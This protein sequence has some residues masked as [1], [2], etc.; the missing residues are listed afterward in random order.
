M[1]LKDYFLSNFL[2]FYYRMKVLCVVAVFVAVAWAGPWPDDMAP[3]HATVAPRPYLPDW[4]K[5]QI[6]PKRDVEVA[7][8]GIFETIKD[9]VTS[10]L[11]AG[12]AIKE[13][14]Q[15]VT[16]RVN[17]IIDDIQEFYDDFMEANDGKTPTE[18]ILDVIYQK[19]HDE[20]L[21][22]LDVVFDEIDAVFHSVADF[23]DDNISGVWGEAI[24][25]KGIAHVMESIYSKYI[26]IML[27]TVRK[28]INLID[29]IEHEDWEAFVDKLMDSIE[30]NL[31]AK[32][33]KFGD[34]LRNSPAYKR[35]LVTR[36]ER[37]APYG[38]LDTIKD[39]VNGMIET[40]VGIKD[41]IAELTKTLNE[42]IDSLREFYEDY[43]EQ[44][45]KTPT[46]AF[47]EHVLEKLHDDIVKALDVVFDQIDDVFH[48]VAD[49]VDEMLEDVW[50]KELIRKGI[51]QLLESLYSKYIDAVLEVLQMAIDT[52]DFIEHEDWDAFV[53][54]LMDSIEASLDAKLDEFG[55]K[56]KNQGKRAVLMSRS[57]ED[58]STMG[59][60]DSIKDFAQG[61]LDAGVAIKEK[62]ADMSKQV[63]DALHTIAEWYK[64]ITADQDGKPVTDVILEKLFEKIVSEIGAIIEKIF[65]EIADVVLNVAEY[66]DEML[67]GVWEEAYIR[68]KIAGFLEYV[69]EKYVKTVMNALQKILDTIDF[70]ENNDWEA[71]ADGVVDIIESAMH[72]KLDEISEKIKDRLGL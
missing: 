44:E 49:Y 51:N 65:D 21:N 66:I 36:T 15:Q 4:A 40:G 52:I 61:M 14:V 62:I 1:S 47:L 29:F 16:D 42:I 27:A 50:G 23:V 33:D 58:V 25:R 70:I 37:L 19:L 31:D 69:M 53:D 9:A 72:E 6:P 13:K 38:F 8:Y 7:P 3:P 26:D 54:R 34:R 17:A 22:L 35:S 11:E 32:L 12:V 28:A 18:A 30:A 64:N 5:P 39:V 46:E 20:I 56:L 59:I 24:V 71:T 41:K 63:A 10:M 67:R 60:V 57:D 2:F 43:T 68:E 45:G 55:D 48:S